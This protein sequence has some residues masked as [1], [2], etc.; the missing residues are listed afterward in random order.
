[1]DRFTMSDTSFNP[2]DPLFLASRWIDGDLSPE[3]LRQLEA[4][5]RRDPSF[6][7][8]VEQ[9]KST[10]DLL[11]RWSAAEPGVDWSRFERVIGDLAVPESEARELDQV[12]ALLQRYSAREPDIDWNDFAAGVMEE[13]GARRTASRLILAWRVGLPLA[14]AA[15]IALAVTAIPWTAAPIASPLPTKHEPLAAAPL[16]DVTITPSSSAKWSTTGT[17]RTVVAFAR[18]A[19]PC[20]GPEPAAAEMTLI[21]V[22]DRVSLVADEYPSL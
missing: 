4:A 13:I 18:D 19:E 11:G 16:I 12:D 6:A 5:M 1:M 10:N 15:A 17:V 21:A 7:R 8:E 20:I 2:N 22:S 9:L 3:E 14:A